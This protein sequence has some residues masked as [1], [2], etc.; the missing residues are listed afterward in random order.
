MCVSKLL[1]HMEVDRKQRAWAETGSRMTFK[2]P[3]HVA[4]F[5]QW[6]CRPFVGS[7]TS[8]ARGQ[9][10]NIDFLWETFLTQTT[11]PILFPPRKCLH[12]Q[13]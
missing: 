13:G 6:G 5:L 10:S 1:A 7:R 2:G 12:P 11:I 9:D 8:L 3:P 4:Y